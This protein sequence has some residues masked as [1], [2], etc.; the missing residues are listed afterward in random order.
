MATDSR[1]KLDLREVPKAEGR[2]A[3]SSVA[4][5]VI[6][7]FSSEIPAHLQQSAAAVSSQQQSAVSSSQQSAAAAAVSGRQQHTMYR[8]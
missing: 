6:V 8:A 2:L 7:E 1:R 3:T 5:S 4:D